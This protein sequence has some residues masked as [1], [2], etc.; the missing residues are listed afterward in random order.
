MTKV[1][2][3][4]AALT[5]TAFGIPGRNF[6]FRENHFDNRFYATLD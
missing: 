4:S 5:S 1:L 3:I 6:E 2:Q